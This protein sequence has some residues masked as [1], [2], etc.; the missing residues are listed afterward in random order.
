MLLATPGAVHCLRFFTIGAV[1]I[2]VFL[3]EPDSLARP[4]AF[5]GANVVNPVVTA[6]PDGSQGPS[7]SSLQGGSVPMLPGFRFLFAAIVLSM[8]VL[9]LGLGAAAVLR[10]AHEQF[11]ESGTWRP[12]SDTSVA[13]QSDAA[14]PVLAM[15]RVEPRA[16]AP[17]GADVAPVP[18]PAQPSETASS[19][20]AKAT[21]ALDPQSP[22]APEATKSDTPDVTKADVAK[23]DVA[24]EAPKTEG[25]E[26]QVANVAAPPAPPETTPQEAPT[27]Q[28]AA[29]V[30]V[31]TA[32]DTQTAAADPTPLATP[33]ATPAPAAASAPTAA[34]PISAP[35]VDVPAVVSTSEAPPAQS[36]PPS[37][38][39]AVNPATARIATLGG[40]PVTIEEPGARGELDQSEATKKERAEERA[41]RQ[42]LAA[43][44]AKLARQAAQAQAANPFAQSG[45]TLQFIQP[46]LANAT[47]RAR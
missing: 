19:P 30:E 22:P 33:V 25:A 37:A 32:T 1:C 21:P 5:R 24:H 20:D 17:Q 29:T 2:A 31:P 28:P 10:A 23:P 36:E 43:R 8:S 18:A 41:R 6:F 4:A 39:V 14:A 7:Q 42:R 45:P 35:A 13:Q 11:A 9:V 38:P 26:T 12:A 16:T 44:R 46:G 15:L 40:P 34:P 3:N 27:A 47:A